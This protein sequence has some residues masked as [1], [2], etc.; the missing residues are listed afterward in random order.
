MDQC[1]SMA[2]LTVSDLQRSKRF[3]EDGLRWKPLGGHQSQFSV[4]YLADGVLRSH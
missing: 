2:M 3:Y 1:L 4:K